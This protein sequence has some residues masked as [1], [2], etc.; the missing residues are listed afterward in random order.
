MD[1]SVNKET[2]EKIRAA[3]ADLHQLVTSSDIPVSRERSAALK[4]LEESCILA[5]LALVMNEPTPEAA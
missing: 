4:K 3:Y 2:V 1:G 5:N